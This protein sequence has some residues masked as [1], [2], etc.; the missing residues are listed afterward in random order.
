[1]SNKLVAPLFRKEHILF[2]VLAGFFI[3]N[4]LIAEFIGV[5]IFSLEET[6]GLPQLKLHLFGAERSFDL[7]AGVL[8]WPVIF[9]MTD[10]IN[11]YYGVRGV[12]ILSLLAAGLITYGFLMFFMG[13]QLAPS[14]FWPTS[15]VPLDASP[16]ER[17]AILEKVSDFDYAFFVVFGQG[18]WII[19]GSL[20]AFL[21][22]QLLDAYVFK[23]IKAATG[24]GRVWLRAT[25][26]TLVSQFVDSFIVLFIAFYVSGKMPLD[27]VIGI[28]IV[29]Y[30]FK[31]IVAIVLTP[32]LY[33]VH[34]LIERYLGHDLALEMRRRAVMAPDEQ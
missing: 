31:F 26:S 1:M 25:G 20:V 34:G 9:V 22:G 14:G 6:F 19:A 4:A 5:K 29:N 33:L 24:D 11:D 30:V 17:Q 16:A 28:G 8:L 15:H 21:V 12:R 3:A 32:L 10:I 7:T 2:I 18:L 27:T 13:I 23:R